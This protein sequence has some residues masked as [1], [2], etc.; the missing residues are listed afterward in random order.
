MMDSFTINS[1]RGIS[2]NIS[3]QAARLKSQMCFQD[4]RTIYLVFIKWFSLKLEIVADNITLIDTLFKT[5]SWKDPFTI[6]EGEKAVTFNFHCSQTAKPDISSSFQEHIDNQNLST[7]F[8]TF[9]FTKRS[10]WSAKARIFLTHTPD[11]VH[12]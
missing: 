3:I 6:W 1:E 11:A 9:T 4:K 10:W 2:K 12:K 8:I 7:S 5:G